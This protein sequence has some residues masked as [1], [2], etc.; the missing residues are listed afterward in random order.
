M[1]LREKNATG[2]APKGHLLHY[3]YITITILEVKFAILHAEKW[4]P[5][6]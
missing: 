5:V 4:F 2:A 6:V 3:I 1:N